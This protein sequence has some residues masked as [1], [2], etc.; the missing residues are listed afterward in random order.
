MQSFLVNL[1]CPECGATA[2][3]DRLQTYC[4]ACESP[5]L[6]R[7]DLTGV[8]RAAARAEFA[9]RPRGMWRWRE[10]L[11]VRH[12]ANIV[13]LGEG[14]GP[15]LPARRLGEELGLRHLFIKDEGTNPTGTFKARGLAAAVSKAKEPGAPAL[16]VPT[17]GN[18]GGSLA[19]YA[20]RAGMPAHVYMPADA[21]AVNAAECRAAGADVRLMV[22]V[23]AAGCA[24][25]VRAFEAGEARCRTWENAATIAAGLRVPNPF[26]DRLILRAVRESGGTAVAVTDEAIAAAV[27]RMARREGVWP[28]PEGAATLAAAEKLAA[29]GWL[30][31][32]ERIVLFNT[33]TGLKYAV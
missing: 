21:P 14:D 27:P 20:A 22:S 32:D 29:A 26:A 10:V 7:Y 18:A 3:P 5:Y 15:L 8:S 9:A 17:A 33:G 1:I 12:P 28:A 23:Q 6:A 4:H 11:P 2:D 24:P 25:V 13:T 30:T 19:A 31:P 16:V